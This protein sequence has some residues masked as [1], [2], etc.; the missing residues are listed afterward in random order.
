MKNIRH[1][2]GVELDWVEQFSQALEGHQDGINI[3]D[4][5]AIFQGSRCILSI[6][7]DVSVMFTDGV[8][9]QDIT[10]QLKNTSDDFVWVWYN[11]NDENSQFNAVS[12]KTE[13]GRWNFNSLVVDSKLN[14]NYVVK[15]D[16]NTFS[17]V[18]FI[19]K[20]MIKKHLISKNQFKKVFANT[21]DFKKHMI[22]SMSRM[23]PE[24]LF[25][26]EEFRREI[27]NS[28]DNTDIFLSA[29]TFNLMSDYLD[30]YFMQQN[31][32]ISKIKAED[33][34]AIVDSQ[35]YI[36][37]N[38]QAFPGIPVLAQRA[39]MSETKY[40]K[41]FLKITGLTPNLFYQNHKL[42]IS[43]KML[44]SQKYT[45]GEI[46]EILNYSTSSHFSRQFKSYFGISPK[47][48]MLSIH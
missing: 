25:L 9:Q 30:N 22:F 44:E 17:L 45:V 18:L 20:E 1:R 29:L 38:I 43:R 5:K 34:E 39:E 40:K 21:F 11:L 7:S 36:F 35:E 15:K 32:V 4:S 16:T 10:F 31:I 26:I 42:R 23:S 3:I 24:S 8:Y 14:V 47:E 6:T 48:Y 37:K 12:L 28:K 33:V 46:V 2:F 27:K 41:M 19:K 13:V